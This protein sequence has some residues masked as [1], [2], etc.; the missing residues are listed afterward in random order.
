MVITGEFRTSNRILQLAQHKESKSIWVTTPG[1]LTWGNQES[2]WLLSLGALG[3]VPSPRIQTLAQNK[4]DFSNLNQNLHLNLFREREEG[5]AKTSR[6]SCRE[7]QYEQAAR[8]ATPRARSRSSQVVSPHS[9]WCEYSCPV[10]HISPGVQKTLVS[11][12]IVQLARPKT[13]HPDFRVNRQ[14]VETHITHAAKTA[15]ITSRLEQLCLPKLRESSLFY[16][17]SRPESPI[18]PVSRGA[19]RATASARVRQLSTPKSLC[20]DYIP[21]RDL[22]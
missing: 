17:P 15:R 18:R 2:I 21:P 3:A 22:D 9:D 16:P 19:S 12:R 8:M 1:K 13:T 5:A 10:W 7:T 4:P 14:A 6:P 20:K 11:P